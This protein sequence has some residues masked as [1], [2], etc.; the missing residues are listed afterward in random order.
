MIILSLTVSYLVVVR[1]DV[2]DV[3]SIVRDA[4]ARA[5]LHAGMCYVAECSRIGWSTVGKQHPNS[6]PNR[7]A[8]ETCGWND[9]RNG[10][11]GPIP[12]SVIT[13][14]GLDD[15]PQDQGDTYRVGAGSGRWPDVGSSVR[16]SVYVWKRSPYAVH[17]AGNPVVI[18]ESQDDVPASGG[19]F[20]PQYF[21]NN[22]DIW[23]VDVPFLGTG[24]GPGRVS[25]AGEGVHNYRNGG[26]GGGSDWY[27]NL[28]RFSAQP[29]PD[30]S[31]VALS[32]AE[33]NAGDPAP[34]SGRAA[35]FRVYRET[36]ADHNGDNYPFYD[37]VNLNGDANA[38]DNGSVFIVTCGAGTTQG[39]R[40]WSEVETEL[41][42]VN[43]T[44]VFGD[45][46]AF[47]D[48]RRDESV[49]WFRV[50]WTPYTQVNL[51]P[52]GA[53]SHNTSSGDGANLKYLRDMRAAVEF[54]ASVQQHPNASIGLWHF[55]NANKQIQTADP[56]PF[57]S[58]RWVQAL[59]REPPQW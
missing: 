2:G 40:S 9:I 57:G 1:S 4:Q 14:A 19:Y 37:T 31:P 52:Y 6:R 25:E 24:T 50:E 29:K 58:F 39:F 23:G 28:W 13:A 5:M 59:D 17:L 47:W 35:W 46:T 42:A 7:F 54:Q 36:A 26:S 22:H 30:P 53:L 3:Q 20:L 8:A 56:M 33:Y 16:Q 51:A 32:L 55:Q 49:L 12:L 41:G 10:A 43:A 15:R 48:R 44:H 27:G 38:P 11:I 18:H 45:E 34:R 21:G